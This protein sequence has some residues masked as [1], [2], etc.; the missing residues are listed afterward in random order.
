MQREVNT[1]EGC[2][3]EGVQE[4]YIRSAQ[5]WAQ[6]RVELLAAQNAMPGA[7]ENGKKVNNSIWR[8]YWATHQ[9]NVNVE[10]DAGEGGRM[11][12]HNGTD[13]AVCGSDSSDTC[14]WLQRCR[15]LSS[16]HRRRWQRASVW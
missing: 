13:L 15:Q 16:W 9:V 6:L 8:Y 12:S 5:F 2:G 10:G 11:C 14:V 3:E 1:E 4:M 7:G